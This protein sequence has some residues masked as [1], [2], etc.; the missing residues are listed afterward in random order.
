MSLK[1]TVLTAAVAALVTVMVT[2]ASVSTMTP[3]VSSDT[4]GAISGTVVNTPTLFAAGH[5]DG[6]SIVE[7]AADGYIAA[8]QNQAAWR[9]TTGRVVYVKPG[10]VRIGFTSG[11]AS[12]SL[13]LF[14]G[15]SSASSY[16][17]FARPT[18]TTLLIDA[19]LV[20]TSTS[21]SGGPITY[22][23]TTTSSGVGIAVPAN[24]YV[25]FNVQDRYFCK[26]QGACETATSTNRGISRFLWSLRGSYQP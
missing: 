20:A 23:G 8:G 11:T 3:S 25:V 24:S 1:N 12:S 9:N 13:A 19:A 15:T 6:G 2:L 7:F 18:I 22:V 16:S 4:L 21:A 14:V 17:D 5:S 26:A 10:D